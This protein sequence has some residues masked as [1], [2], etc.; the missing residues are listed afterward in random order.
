MT[1]AL[2]AVSGDM[3]FNAAKPTEWDLWSGRAAVRVALSAFGPLLDVFG[4]KV[5]GGLN[6][7]LERDVL[8]VRGIIASI[9]TIDGTI[10]DPDL[11]VMEKLTTLEAKVRGLRMAAGK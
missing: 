10:V 7:R 1:M 11:K 9:A 3:I 8:T 6:A 5:L 4:S 2:T